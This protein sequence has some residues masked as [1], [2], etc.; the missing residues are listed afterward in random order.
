MDKELLKILYE[1]YSREIYL[2]LFSLCHDRELAQDLMQETFL[3]AILSLSDHHTNMRAWMY[4]VARNLY[5]NHAKREKRYCALEEAGCGGVDD[6]G[7]VLERM[8]SDERKRFLYQALDRLE[9]PYKEVLLMQYFGGLSQK[10][11]A[12]VL[13]MT[14]ENVRITAYR[15]KRKIREFMEVSGYDIS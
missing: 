3:K 2:Y 8:I 1:K 10:E 14:P 15:A 12:A 9:K 4:M 13:H 11:I 5:F 6:T 7:Q